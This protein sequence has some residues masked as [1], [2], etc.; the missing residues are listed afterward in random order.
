MLHLHM[1]ALI[2]EHQLQAVLLLKQVGKDNLIVMLTHQSFII[3]TIVMRDSRRKA[4]SLFLLHWKTKI[5]LAD[6]E[7]TKKTLAYEKKVRKKRLL[8]IINL[9]VIYSSTR[10]FSLHYFCVWCLGPDIQFLSAFRKKCG[11]GKGVRGK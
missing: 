3:H 9:F 5:R 11:L 10:L 8:P 6:N 2:I 7:V 4:K 1:S